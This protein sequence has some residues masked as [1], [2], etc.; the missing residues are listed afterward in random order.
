MVVNEVK[1]IWWLGC[2]GGGGVGG[3]V[4]ICMVSVAR[5]LTQLVRRQDY[6]MWPD[7]TD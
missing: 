7:W 2:G 6:Y 4:G 5:I 1:T 3:W